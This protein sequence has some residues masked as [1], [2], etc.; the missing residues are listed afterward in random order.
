MPASSLA[1]SEHPMTGASKILTVSYGTFSCTL[2]G[3]DDPFNTMKAIAEYFRDLAAGDRYFGAEPPTP[4]AAMLHRI[5]E[6]EIQRRV[7]AKIQ[8]NG[9]ILRAGDSADL[10]SAPAPRPHLLDAEASSESVAA[11]LQR[12]RA[13]H[14]DIN[15]PET[16]SPK[17][18]SPDA[19]A[20]DQAAPETVS[21]LSVAGLPGTADIYI[22]DQHADP[23]PVAV[24]PSLIEAPDQIEPLLEDA[25][26]S[27]ALA[28]FDDTLAEAAQN[29]PEAA[30]DVPEAL[31]SER[32]EPAEHAMAENAPLQPV[33][34][35]EVTAETPGDDDLLAEAALLA[36]LAEDLP[37]DHAPLIDTTGEPLDLPED[38]A[39]FDGDFDEE[40][41]LGRL[42]LPE[43]V[44]EV[45]E[46][47]DL[48]LAD[49]AA[50]LPAAEVA[51]TSEAFDEDDDAE[52]LTLDALV[53]E[54]TALSDAPA[55]PAPVEAHAEEPAPGERAISEPSTSEPATT[56]TVAAQPA[57]RARARVIRIRRAEP[58]SPASETPVQAKPAPAATGP[59]EIAPAETAALSA[60]AEAALQAELAALEAEIG[61]DTAAPVVADVQPVDASADLRQQIVAPAEDDAVNRLMAQANSEMGGEETRRR[62]SAIA[63]L[64]AAVAATEADRMI[65][66]SQGSGPS[67]RIE[68]YRDDLE[69]VVRPRRPQAEGSTPRPALPTE[70][71]ARP[72]P[73]VLVS[74]QRIDAPQPKDSPATGPRV[75]MPVRPRRVGGSGPTAADSLASSGA[76]LQA[77]DQGMVDDDDLL[78]PG[79]ADNV[80]ADATSF[81]DFADQLGATA[82]PDLLEAAA[83]YCAEVLQRPEF[84]RPLVMR[85]VAALAGQSDTAREDCMRGFGTLLRQGRITKVKRGMFALTDRSPYL[86]EA[87]KLAG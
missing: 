11:R 43:A 72:T 70:A 76:R 42:A 84:S 77:A 65:S 78:A 33:P 55:P 24:A 48:N 22:E 87:R 75:V 4:D 6:R 23:E 52:A 50:D 2:E 61:A 49:P 58:A 86:A 20:P 30:F 1:E 80:F 83:V 73:L 44:A 31:V 74:A 17:T 63:H 59:A 82:L 9:V 19:T 7:E 39:A 66:G 13:R 3:F 85:Q 47:P 25:G 21:T 67:N 62:Q 12:I 71:P 26:T 57:G 68:A 46:E 8:D 34:A 28:G 37:E 54:S 56:D 81:Q 79:E 38:R 41:L 40:A 32:P 53:A 27:A 10:P 15:P 18:N 29:L 64:K 16:N 5:A 45:I 51:D 36:S 69:R 60:E 35:P 14:A